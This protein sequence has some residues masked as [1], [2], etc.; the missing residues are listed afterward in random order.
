M[1]GVHASDYGARRARMYP[2]FPRLRG[3][4][5]ERTVFIVRARHD[6]KIPRHARKKGEKARENR[7]V[8]HCYAEGYRRSETGKRGAQRHVRI[9]LGNRDR[10]IG[11]FARKY[12][13]GM[14]RVRVQARIKQLSFLRTMKKI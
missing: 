11:F 7:G 13:K 1:L 12:L 2:P 8:S 10:R 6:G 3:L 4:P 9:S 5:V 14:G